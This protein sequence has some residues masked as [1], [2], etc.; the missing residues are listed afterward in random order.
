[1]AA[2]SRMRIDKWLWAVRLFR[3][4]SLASQACHGGHVK[5]DGQRVKPSREVQAGDLITAQTGPVQRTVKVLG[6]LQ[7]RVG[8]KAVPEYLE[9]LTPP[10]EYERARLAAE[11]PLLQYPKG[12]GRPT[13][14]RRREME[15]WWSS[16]GGAGLKA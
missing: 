10:E 13:K 2:P 15:G 3:S 1:M 9:D 8:A 12:W 11:P 7:Q 14:K 5:V 4:R 16:E 6:L